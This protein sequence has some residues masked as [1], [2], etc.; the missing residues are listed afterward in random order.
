MN[1]EFEKGML[2]ESTTF[3][4]ASAKLNYGNK[5]LLLFFLYLKAETQVA[6]IFNN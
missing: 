1:T 6:C 5:L 3:L 4:L 2:K